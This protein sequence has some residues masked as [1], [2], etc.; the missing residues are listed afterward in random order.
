MRI[1][2]DNPDYSSKEPTDIH[3]ESFHDCLFRIITMKTSIINPF[4]LR[5]LIAGLGLILAGRVAA[6]TFTNL[7]NFTGF[8]DG[9]TPLAGLIVSGNTLYGAADS[10]GSAFNGTVFKANLN[11]TGLTNLHTFTATLDPDY[12]NGDGAYPG[13][14][15]LLSGTTLYGTASQGGSSGNG[16]VFAV[17]TDGTVFTNLHSFTGPLYSG[18]AII[19]TDGADPVA[20]LILSGSTLYGTAS[21][22]GSSGNGTVFAINT[23]GTS[24]TNLHSFNYAS[25]GANPQGSLILI[26]ST[27]Y[28]TANQAAVLALGLCSPSTPTARVLRICIVSITAT[29]L[30]RRPD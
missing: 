12:T 7:Y 18:P 26:G 1:Q 5:V 30:I 17:N 11:G 3:R 4:L 24:F 8:T 21:Q 22:G 9:S 13:G 28:G 10:G 2:L 23:N 19:N 20:G 27:L 14:V 25:D 15:L 29:E 6:Q 16:T